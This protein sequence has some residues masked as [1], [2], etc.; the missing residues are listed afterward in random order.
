MLSVTSNAL[1]ER[2]YAPEE[3]GDGGTTTTTTSGSEYPATY[4]DFSQDRYG[5]SETEQNILNEMMQTNQKPKQRRAPKHTSESSVTLSSKVTAM[6]EMESPYQSDAISVSGSVMSGSVDVV[7]SR[8]SNEEVAFLWGEQS[9]GSGD[10]E[11]PISPITNSSSQGGGG[12]GR[13]ML[14]KANS[15]RSIGSYG[16][17]RAHM[18][19][20]YSATSLYSVGEDTETSDGASDVQSTLS[21]VMASMSNEEWVQFSSAVEKAEEQQLVVDQQQQLNESPNQQPQELDDNSGRS[22]SKLYAMNNLSPVTENTEKTDDEAAQLKRKKATKKQASEGGGKSSSRSV[23]ESSRR[24]KGG[25]K[26]TVKL[27]VSPGKSPTAHTASTREGRSKNRRS[28]GGSAVSDRL[29]LD[30]MAKEEMDGDL[31]VASKSVSRRKKSSN[32]SVSKRSGSGDSEATRGR[33]KSSSKKSPSTA[34][35]E[36]GDKQPSMSALPMSTTTRL[37]DTTAPMST[38]TT[39]LNDTTLP[40]STTTRLNDTMAMSTPKAKKERMKKCKSLSP[41]DALMREPSLHT[42]FEWNKEKGDG[43]NPSDPPAGTNKVVMST[44]TPRACR[45]QK[46]DR[47]KMFRKSYSTT[48]V[49]QFSLTPKWPPKRLGNR[50][51][52][53]QFYR[54]QTNIGE[55]VPE[56]PKK[57]DC[58][59]VSNDKMLEIIEP[60]SMRELLRLNGF[61]EGPLSKREVADSCVNYADILDNQSVTSSNNSSRK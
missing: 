41:P 60:I 18:R 44:E 59:S 45:P 19:R 13:Y 35:P 56:Q 24:S 57:K 31:S 23:S 34:R 6:T 61:N 3:D 33:S 21:D 38:T 5:F 27:Q 53:A 50:S 16:N 39:R 28:T 48:D 52:H 43:S 51:L 36:L 55:M 58:G 17:R 29:A 10:Y 8:L 49:N 15:Q 37:N 47:R 1:M 54:R 22:A 2:E 11:E 9:S 4:E 7:R 46:L 26:K 25:T 40:M 12:N 20:G 42:I 14:Q 30:E 32:K